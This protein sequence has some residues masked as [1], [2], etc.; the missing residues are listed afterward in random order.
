MNCSAALYSVD[1]YTIPI[2]WWI[3]LLSLG[4]AFVV[5]AICF[6]FVARMFNKK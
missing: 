6:L 4:V 1:Y 5:I 3:T 2:P